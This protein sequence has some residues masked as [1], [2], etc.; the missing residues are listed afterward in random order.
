MEKLKTYQVI[1]KAIQN[2][3]TIDQDS[4]TKA[5]A[6]IAK[7][8]ADRKYYDRVNFSTEPTNETKAAGLLSGLFYFERSELGVTFWLTK[9][10][11]PLKQEED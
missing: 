11:E 1:I 9:I 5:L 3:K 2:S 10:T 8:R 6:D 7:M 4:K